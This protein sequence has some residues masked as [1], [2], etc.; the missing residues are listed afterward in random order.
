[1]RW[2]FGPPHLTLK[3]TKRK[4][5]KKHKQKMKKKL[6][7]PRM[8]FNYQSN[9]SFLFG[10]GPE[11]PFLTT[12]PKK[13]APPK[14]YI[15]RGFSKHIFG[16]QIT[17][18]KRPFLDKNRSANYQVLLTFFFSL[19]NKNTR[20]CWDPH[21]YSA[22]ANIQKENFQTL[23]LKQGYFN[24]NCTQKRSNC[25]NPIFRKIAWYLGT[26][27]HKMITECAKST[28]NRYKNRLK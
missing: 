25:C 18:T 15:N 23:N 12:W 4:N 14:H 21:F 1:M 10:G 5:K 27:K 26:K 19:N 17:V 6:N 13:S 16:K 8:L 7:T 3:T 11:F 2:P 24:T 22:L 20:T 9:L 28:W